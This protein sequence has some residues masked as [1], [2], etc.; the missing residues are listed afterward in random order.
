MIPVFDPSL[1]CVSPARHT[2]PQTSHDAADAHANQ[3]DTDRDKVRVLL[4]KHPNGL[5][6]FELADLMKRQQTSV[7]KRRG[8]LRD[9]GLVRDSG[10]RRPSPSGSAAIVWESVPVGQRSIPGSLF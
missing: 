10:R 6:D 1:A 5:T 7:G 8:E 9:A 3:R 4:S 2:D